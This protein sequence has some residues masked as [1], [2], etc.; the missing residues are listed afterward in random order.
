MEKWGWFGLGL[1]VIVSC[2]ARKDYRPESHLSPQEQDQVM[3]AVIRYIGKAPENV[4]GDERFDKKYDAYYQQLAGRHR[5]EKYFIDDSGN[6]YFLI[7]RS[8]PSL[9]EK[10]VATGGKMRFDDKW[11]LVEYEE[12]FRTWKMKE[13]ELQK[14]GS[15]LFEKLVTNQPLTPYQAPN[16]TEEYIEFPDPRTYFDKESRTWKT[17]DAIN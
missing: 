16:S 17:R 5:L 2:S 11:N 15:V 9:F 14:K 1:L 12:V 6:H 4:N 7:S 13:D 8:A 3:M 10:R